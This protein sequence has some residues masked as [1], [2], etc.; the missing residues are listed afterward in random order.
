MIEDMNKGEHSPEDLVM[1]WRDN[2]VQAARDILDVHLDDHQRIVLKSRWAHSTEYDVLSRGTGKTFLNAVTPS[3]RCIL[4]PGHRC[5]SDRTVL[6]SVEDGVRGSRRSCGIEARYVP[7]ACPDGPKKNPE[8]CFLRF[9]SAPGKAGSWI[10]ALPLGSD[11]AKIRGARFY[12]VYA[13]E[14]AQIDNDVLNTVVRG[15]LA[16][17]A[18][19]MERVNF[20]REQRD[21]VARGEMTEDQIVLPESNKFIGSST[22]FYMYNHFWERIQSVM[23]EIITPLQG[24]PDQEPSDA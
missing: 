15:F 2:P 13:D 5:G 1:F 22:A 9:S 23:G 21:K 16:T 4:W 3:L 12:D 10:E 20:M 7:A 18:N 14:L 11:G 8:S 17:S 24:V 6:P 19:P